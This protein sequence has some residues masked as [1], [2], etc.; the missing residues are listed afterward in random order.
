M[1]GIL[2]I[3]IIIGDQMGKNMELETEIGTACGGVTVMT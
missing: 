2:L 3:P 1:L